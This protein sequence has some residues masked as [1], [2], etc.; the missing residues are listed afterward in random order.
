MNLN[1]V[2]L[3]HPSFSEGPSDANDFLEGHRW[4]EK[5]NQLDRQDA[6]PPPCNAKLSWRTLTSFVSLVYCLNMIAAKE[7]KLRRKQASEKALQ[8]Q[9]AIKAAQE[10]SSKRL[11]HAKPLKPHFQVCPIQPSIA[12]HSCSPTSMIRTLICNTNLPIRM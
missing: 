9:T 1:S 11:P 4:K 12:F 2:T 5:G 10:V 6:S 7:K 8:V 3:R